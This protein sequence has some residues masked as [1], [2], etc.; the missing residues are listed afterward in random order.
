MREI[1]SNINIRFN[2]SFACI[3]KT[4]G[5][6]GNIDVRGTSTERPKIV[7]Q[8]NVNGKNMLGIFTRWKNETELINP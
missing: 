3:I 1:S 7:Y 8:R 4:Y 2:Y 6:S 5:E